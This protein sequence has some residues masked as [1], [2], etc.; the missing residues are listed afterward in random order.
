MEAKNKKNSSFTTVELIVSITIMFIFGG[1][2]LLNYNV[3]KDKVDLN[4][5]LSVTSQEVRKAQSLAMAQAS[6]PA[7]CGTGERD[8]FGIYFV[9]DK[10]YVFLYV[11]KNGDGIPNI[12][13]DCDPA[14]PSPP[15]PDDLC[16][17]CKNDECVEAKYFPKSIK[18]NTITPN[19]EGG[20]T[21]WIGFSRKDLS[22]KINNDISVSDFQLDFCP[23][24]TGCTTADIK[25]IKMNNKGMV[26]VQ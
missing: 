25:S 13:S 14:D 8:I 20:S 21:G 15:N 17:D 5:A 24:S 19:F 10:N 9:K 11:D 1:T 3:Q 7:E 22:V 12:A 23:T 16:C 26:D 2:F 6:L 18:I 4:N